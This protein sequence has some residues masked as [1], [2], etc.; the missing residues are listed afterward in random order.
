ME[1]AHPDDLEVQGKNMI[2]RIVFIV[3]HEHKGSPREE[4]IINVDE[5]GIAHNKPAQSGFCMQ[6]EKLSNIAN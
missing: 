5:T 1:I 6:G 2:L 3:S 4:L